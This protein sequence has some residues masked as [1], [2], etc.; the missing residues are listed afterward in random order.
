M[1]TTAREQIALKLARV[2]VMF[3]VPALLFNNGEPA[4]SA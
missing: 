2:A 1:A 4:E 3:V